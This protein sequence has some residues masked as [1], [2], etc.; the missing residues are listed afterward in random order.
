[1]YIYLREFRA[2]GRF[3]PASDSGFFLTQDAK[4]PASDS[5]FFFNSGCKKLMTKSDPFLVF[6]YKKTQDAKS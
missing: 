4:K 2:S 1:M 6:F 3:L 5:G